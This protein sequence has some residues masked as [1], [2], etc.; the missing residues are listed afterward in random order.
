[1][2]AQP[3]VEPLDPISTYK[4][5]YDAGTQCFE[6]HIDRKFHTPQNVAGAR[7]HFRI[8]DDKK[9]TDRDLITYFWMN[10]ANAIQQKLAFTT[11]RKLVPRPP[12]S[13]TKVLSKI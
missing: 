1:M 4:I 12:H 8:S 2:N 10:P 11:M 6:R 3:L 13:S 7:K 9:P 5:A